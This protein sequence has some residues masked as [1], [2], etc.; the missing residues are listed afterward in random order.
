MT[1]GDRIVVMAG[2]IVQQAGPPLEV[3]RRPVN[4][5]VAGFIGSPP[6]NFIHGRIADD[7]GLLCF[8]EDRDDRGGTAARIPLASPALRSRAG[9]PAVLGIRPQ[10]ITPTT[11]N[12]AF[13]LHIRIVEPLGDAIDMHGATSAGAPIVARVPSS[14]PARAGDRLPCRVDPDSIHLFEPG[15]LGRNMLV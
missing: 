8:I 15:E 2:G 11:A 6:M 10:A 12:A 7:A 14:H 3:Y 5:F 4:R 9:T 1:L 13:D